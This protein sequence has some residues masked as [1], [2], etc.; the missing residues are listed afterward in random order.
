MQCRRLA[1]AVDKP[2]KMLKNLLKAAGSKTTVLSD[3]DLK[4]HKLE[5]EQTQQMLHEAQKAH[6]K[7]I[8]KT[9]KLLRT[10][11]SDDT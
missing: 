4:P 5:I 10:L 9:C 7:A 11:L 1:K 8:A 3:D 2:A 6:N